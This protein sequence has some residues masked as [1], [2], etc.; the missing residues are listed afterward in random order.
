MDKGFGFIA[1][2]G[3]EKD[4]F[5]HASALIDVDFNS[6]QE[7]DMVTFKVE[8]GPKGLNAVEVSLAPAG[9]AVAADAVEAPA[10]SDTA[11]VSAE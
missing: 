5:F 9:D 4:L 1:R 2:E 11:E 8:E 3:E 7:G 6:L 10:G